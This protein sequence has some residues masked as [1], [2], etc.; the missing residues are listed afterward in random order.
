MNRRSLLSAVIASF[1]LVAIFG[2]TSAQAGQKDEVL[3]AGSYTASV[4][5]LVCRGCGSLV[6]KTLEGLKEIE[7]A[8]VDQQKSTVQFVVKK[9]NTVK[10]A[11]LQKELKAAADKMGMGA[12][13]TLSNVKAAN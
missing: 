9:E 11:D 6:K 5:A 2:V 1:A 12:D 4:K 8:T 3:A 13:Y 7:S 10:L